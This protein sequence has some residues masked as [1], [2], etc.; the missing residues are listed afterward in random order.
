MVAIPPAVAAGV[1]PSGG[2]AGNAPGPCWRRSSDPRGDRRAQPSARRADH[3]AG[4]ADVGRDVRHGGYTQHAAYPTHWGRW[5]ST[6]RRLRRRWRW[7]WSGAAAVE[8][9][10]DRRV[11]NCRATA[12]RRARHRDNRH[13]ARDVDDP[14]VTSSAGRRQEAQMLPTFWWSG[15]TRPGRARR[16][17]G[18]RRRSPRTSRTSIRCRG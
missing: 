14:D 15:V 17:P 11:S 18:G 10:S 12:G 6:H 8:A 16:P 7:W 2:G 3:G 4:G 13:E 1:P 5:T 9:L